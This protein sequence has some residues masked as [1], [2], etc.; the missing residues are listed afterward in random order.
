MNIWPK[1]RYAR[2]MQLAPDKRWANLKII[3]LVLVG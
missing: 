1:R 3:L 2:Y